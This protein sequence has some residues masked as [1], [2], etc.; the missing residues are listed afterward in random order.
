MQNTAIEERHSCVCCSE[1]VPFSACYCLM[2]NMV[3]ETMRSMRNRGQCK[4]AARASPVLGVQENKQGAL[5]AGADSAEQTGE[6]HAALQQS[7][8]DFNPKNNKAALGRYR[9]I[10]CNYEM[11]SRAQIPRCTSCGSRRLQEIEE[12]SV[13]KPKKESVEMPKKEEQPK[14]EPAAEQEEQPEAEEKDDI[15]DDEEEQE[16]EDDDEL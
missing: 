7:S 12:F 4:E 15:F 14:D 10:F 5:T 2:E 8:E 6:A 13:F 11:A 16:G 3:N 9:C 1:A